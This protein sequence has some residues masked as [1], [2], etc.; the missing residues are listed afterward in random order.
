MPTRYP[1]RR[2]E[3]VVYFRGM[4]QSSQLQPPPSN[5]LVDL[6]S[7]TVTQPSAGMRQAMLDAPVGDD[8]F[9]EDESI[10]ALQQRCAEL[11]GH[12]AAL[13][14]PSGTMT[15]QIAIQVHTRPGDEV[16][17][18]YTSPSPRDL[19]TSRMPSSA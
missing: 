6:R 19:S 4:A 12:E 8:V 9:G 17:L 3:T 14:C 13:F 15:N 10:Q 1:T 7:D 5:L 2:F 11:T 16:C 18:L